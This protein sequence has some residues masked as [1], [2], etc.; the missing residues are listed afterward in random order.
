MTKNNNKKLKR[1]GPWGWPTPWANPLN[2]IT[3]VAGPKPLIFY[4]Y[5]YFSA[6]E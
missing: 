5:F 3:P 1:F 4:F 6:M 2:F